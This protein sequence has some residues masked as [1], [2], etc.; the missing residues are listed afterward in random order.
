M[1][2][3]LKDVVGAGPRALEGLVNVS[4]YVWNVTVV[5]ESVK[6]KLLDEV[7]VVKGEVCNVEEILIVY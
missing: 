5:S 2:H 4:K 7:L 6:E 3:G 1:Y